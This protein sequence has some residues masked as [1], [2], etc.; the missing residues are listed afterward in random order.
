MVKNVLPITPCSPVDLS[1]L[2]DRLTGR[3][4]SKYRIPIM[5]CT[6]IFIAGPVNPGRQVDKYG[7]PI[8]PCIDIFTSRPSYLLTFLP[9]LIGPELNIEVQGIMCKSYLFTCRPVNLSTRV[10]RSRSKYMS[11]RDYG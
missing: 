7:L 2:V 11:A 6:P 1:T 8:M 9:G 3:Q 10:D 5:P 4:V